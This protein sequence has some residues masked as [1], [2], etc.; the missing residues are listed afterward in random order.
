MSRCTILRLCSTPSSPVHWC[1][2]RPFWLAQF[3]IAGGAGTTE[4]GIRYG[5]C[6]RAPAGVL[7]F[8]PSDLPVVRGGQV[9]LVAPAHAPTV[10]ACVPIV[11]A[12]VP[13]VLAFVQIALECVRIALECVRI[14]PMS[15]PSSPLRVR[16]ARPVDR[17]GQKRGHSVLCL[18]PKLGPP[19][20]R[21]RKRGRS[22]PHP[23][24]AP[25]LHGRMDARRRSGR[26]RTIVRPRSARRPIDPDR[27]RAHGII[28]NG[29]ARKVNAT[30]DNKQAHLAVSSQIQIGRAKS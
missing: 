20:H 24:R 7:R 2:A 14:A 19:G 8:G 17:P 12:Y 25:D 30:G 9:T 4:T 29:H 3:G 13:T 16:N 11:P 26:E 21:A 5:S 6:R 22:V 10:L 15:G 23:V 28:R 18:A 27:S 1:S